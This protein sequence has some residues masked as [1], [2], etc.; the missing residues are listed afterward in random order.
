M[1]RNP[2]VTI[3]WKKQESVQGQEL[4]YQKTKNN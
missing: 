2:D 3:S 4:F 1:L